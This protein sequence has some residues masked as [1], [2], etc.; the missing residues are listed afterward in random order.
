[1]DQNSEAYKYIYIFIYFVKLKKEKRKIKG[2]EGYFG[3]IT[4]EGEEA[5]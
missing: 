4:S 5:R 2:K 3:Y 1:M